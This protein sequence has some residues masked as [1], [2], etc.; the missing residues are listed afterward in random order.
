MADR[1]GS[2]IVLA[3]AIAWWS[4]FT[5]G[6]GLSFSATSLAA[7]RFLFGA[8]EAAAFPAGSRALVR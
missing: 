4:A 5:A 8:G 7:T 1:F 2:R 6:T 3:A